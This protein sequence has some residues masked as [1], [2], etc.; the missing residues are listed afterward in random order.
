MFTKVYQQKVINYSSNCTLI[1]CLSSSSGS[2]SATH[3]GN[4]IDTTNARTSMEWSFDTPPRN[5]TK[6]RGS[7]S[8]SPF[9]VDSN[10]Q[11]GCSRIITNLNSPS[12]S[13]SY[14]KKPKKVQWCKSIGNILTPEECTNIISHTEQSGLYKPAMINAGFGREIYDP[15]ARNSDRCIIDD[16]N[17]ANAIFDRLIQGSST[18]SKV[19]NG[20]DNDNHNC[21]IPFIHTSS[22]MKWEAV[23]LNERFRI[24]RYKEGNAFPWHRDGNYMRHSKERSFYTI[25]IYLNSGDGIDYRGGSTLF[26]FDFDITKHG[27]GRGR[28]RD[29]ESESESENKAATV[30]Y[31]PQ[32]GGVV[33][34]DHRILHEGARVEEGTKYA[35]RT[36]VMYRLVK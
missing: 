29:C 6:N 12:P 5:K 9:V 4:V 7:A 27:R 21:I 11:Q 15:D 23:G 1:E 13:S 18:G 16:A 35:I 2:G 25:M 36:D 34:F 33:V 20:S 17:F 3:D 28:E 31:V 24:L 14:G 10:E 26:Q 8:T 19:S 22:G 30:E 32:A